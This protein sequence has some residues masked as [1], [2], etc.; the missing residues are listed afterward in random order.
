MELAPI[1]TL[2]ILMIQQN[3]PATKPNKSDYH[4]FPFILLSISRKNVEE[5]YYIIRNPK[6]LIPLNLQPSFPSY[7]KLFYLY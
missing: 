5:D 1:P 4:K 3:K 6:I 2:N 7:F